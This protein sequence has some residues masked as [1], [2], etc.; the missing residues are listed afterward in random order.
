MKTTE[1]RAILDSIIADA[2]KQTLS[3][4]GT[5]LTTIHAGVSGAADLDDVEPA[6]ES[7]PSRSRRN[8]KADAEE[9]PARARR[10]RRAK[11]EDEDEG[12]DD[13]DLS[14]LDDLDDVDED[15][16][17]AKPRSRRN[18]K[19]DAD[20]K[21]ARTSRRK[22]PEPEADEVELPV[23]EEASADAVFD[24]IEALEEVELSLDDIPTGV[25]ELNAMLSGYNIDPKT[26]LPEELEDASRKD[27]ATALAMVVAMAKATEDALA[28]FEEADIEAIA[29]ELEIDVE[30]IKGR[31]KARTRNL[32][33]AI[34]GYVMS[35]EEGD[36][37]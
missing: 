5:I 11:D 36:D 20:E 15:E 28:E 33:M 13:S 32:T 30:S 4:L 3:A 1:I 17:P 26:A 23:I 25:R 27:R 29:E 7:K 12:D 18:R 35:P 31:G 34:I 14:D 22:E 10:N 21:P 37:E 24:F 8:R 2:D 9:K 19:D 16:K 6:V